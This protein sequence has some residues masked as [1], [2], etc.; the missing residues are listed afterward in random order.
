MGRDSLRGLG[1]TLA[2]NS[3][4]VVGGLLVTATYLRFANLGALDF[5]SDE[6][7]YSLAVKGILEHGIPELPSGM[8]YLRGGAFLY[9]TAASAV[10]LGVSEYA[11]RVPA[12]L[13]GLGTIPLAFLFGRALFGNAVGLIVA[14]LVTFSVWDIDFSRYARM[15]APFEFFYLLTLLG[16]WR[17]RVLEENATGGAICIALALVTVSLHDLGY[18]LAIAFLV[19]SALRGRRVLR[20][21][22]RLVFPAFASSAVAVFFFGWR[23]VQDYYFNLAAR[24]SET[25]AVEPTSTASDGPSA[26]VRILDS[27]I[28]PPTLPVLSELW[29]T[30]PSAAIVLVVGPLIAAAVFLVGRRASFGVVPRTLLTGLALSCGLQLFN[31]A[32]LATLVLAFL[33]NEGVHGFRRAD[34]RFAIACIAVSFVVWVTLTLGLDLGGRLQEGTSAALKKTVRELLDYP[35]FFVFWGFPNEYPLMSIPA[36]LGGIWAFDRAAR[37][38]RNQA[39]LFLIAVFAIPMI[40]NGMFATQ[41]QS[42]RYNVPFGPLYFMFVA[43]G[44]TQW[45]QL[46]G[47]HDRRSVFGTTRTAVT[48]ALLIALV[49]AMDV[50]PWRSWYVT[51]QGF[52]FPRFRDFSSPAK[53]VAEHA[54]EDDTIVVFDCREFYNYLGQLDYCVLSSTYIYEDTVVQTYMDGDLRRDLYVST[55]MLMNVDELKH[56]LQSTPGTKWL[57]AS[58]AMMA[59]PAAVNEDIRAFVQSND[60]RVAYVGRDGDG[61]VYRF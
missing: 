48:T 37:E 32:L 15:Y 44:L 34:V 46:V 16:I 27:Y 57:I 11:L 17:Y 4:W 47:V 45:Q 61:K 33:K 21:P 31:V 24:M 19:P 26:L 49:L 42:F 39:A 1:A 14:A 53:Y 36:L 56:A 35:H 51:R 60:E 6:D 25:V 29:S 13:I 9:V 50:N 3:W 22:R 38:P 28:D 12:A 55:P 58:D 5:R 2:A 7:L 10:L 8:V 20:E 54:D 40:S 52:E 18:T 59:N 43:L 23:R 41:Y 30:A